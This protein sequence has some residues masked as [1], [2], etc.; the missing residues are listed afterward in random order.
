MVWRWE[1]GCWELL[2][3]LA[4]TGEVGRRYE[5]VAWEQAKKSPLNTLITGR[6]RMFGGDCF[7][8]RADTGWS[9]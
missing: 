4:D 7:R 1:L 8:S 9:F 6:N 2:S 3:V 5:E